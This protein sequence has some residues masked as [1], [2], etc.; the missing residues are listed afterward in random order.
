MTTI[1]KAQNREIYSKF[2]QSYANSLNDF[3][4]SMI[5][6]SMPVLRRSG[7]AYSFGHEAMRLM[8]GKRAV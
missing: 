4:A 3:V 8:A 5:A 6:P 7:E 2:V 1:D